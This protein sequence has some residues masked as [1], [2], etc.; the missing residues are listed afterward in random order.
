MNV[1]FIVLCIHR[2]QRV[3]NASLPML[4]KSMLVPFMRAEM[5]YSRTREQLVVYTKC[6]H[7]NI[8]VMNGLDTSIIKFNKLLKIK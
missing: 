7:P 2:L 8:S 1:I 6:Q 5:N 3:M 4:L